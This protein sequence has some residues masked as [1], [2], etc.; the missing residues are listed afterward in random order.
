MKRYLLIALSLVLVFAFCSAVFAGKSNS[1][2]I[3]EHIYYEKGFK[4]HLVVMQKEVVDENGLRKVTAGVIDTIQHAQTD[5]PDTWDAGIQQPG[6]EPDTTAN[7][8]WFAADTAE[9]LEIHASFATTG[10]GSWNVWGIGYNDYGNV[11]PNTAIKYLPLDIPWTIDNADTNEAGEPTG[12]WQ[13]LNV[14]ELLGQAVIP[15][16]GVWTGYYYDANGGP[17]SFMDDGEHPRS[18]PSWNPTRTYLGAYGGWYIW[19]TSVNWT[20]LVQRLVVYYEKV[21]PLIEGLSMIPDYFE[22]NPEFGDVS[23]TIRDLDGTVASANLVYQVGVAGEE[24]VM[25]MT[26]MG[27]NKWSGSVGN[28]YS[29]GDTVHYWVTTEDAEGN[30]RESSSRSFMVIT[31]PAKGTDILV[32]NNGAEISTSNL[33]KPLDELSKDYFVWDVGDHGGIS[34]FEIDWDYN[35]IIWFGFGSGNMADPFSTGDHAVK[36]HLDNGGNLLLIDPDYLYYWIYPAAG[37]T[38]PLEAGQFGYDYLGLHDGISDPSIADTNFFGMAEDPISG[39]YLPGEDTLTT[40]S[41]YYEVWNADYATDWQDFLIPREEADGL[42]WNDSSKTADMY[43]AI[44]YSTGDY[45]TA[46]FAFRLAGAD[47][48][49]VKDVLDKTLAWFAE[50]TAIDDYTPVVNSY[51]LD[52][53]YPNPFNPTTTINFSIPIADRVKLTVYNS[54]GQE[55]INLVNTDMNSGYHTVAWNGLNDHGK[56]A[57]SGVYYYKLEAGDFSSVKKMLLLK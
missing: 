40:Y 10:T 39:A 15:S 17:Y 23:A 31:P 25:A 29:G 13:V 26:D 4:H 47:S 54:L 28:S 8:Y 32:V 11:I 38:L 45:S 55:V 16:D 7:W 50:A 1:K 19:A 22:G 12:N 42:F 3:N 49:K 21:A 46:F 18:D 5:A 9:L 14:Q 37:D 41:T 51:S 44:R 56:K 2:K 57:S 20:G 43:T 35:N 36:D 27:D 34:D 33:T 30:Y 48:M 53:N 6:Y 24:Q 52:Q